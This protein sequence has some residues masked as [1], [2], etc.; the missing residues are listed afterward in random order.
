V[1]ARATSGVR[2]SIAARKLVS[3]PCV[4]ALSM[5]SAECPDQNE[6]GDGH[7][8]QPEQQITSHQ[9]PPQEAVVE[10]IPFLKMGSICVCLIRYDGWLS[11]QREDS[12]PRPF[13]GPGPLRAT[14]STSGETG[15]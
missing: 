13:A 2:P 6:N 3:T 14:L 7:T 8:E 4:A 9:L 10:L 12:K 11:D 1:S 15:S 5:Q